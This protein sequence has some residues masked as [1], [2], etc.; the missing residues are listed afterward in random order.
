V[1]D[2]E[3]LPS[4]GSH[5]VWGPGTNLVDPQGEP[6]ED[7]YAVLRDVGYPLS[8]KTQ[9]D[10][11]G[12]FFGRTDHAHLPIR[13][14]GTWIAVRIDDVSLRGS[15]DPH[16]TG[17]PVVEFQVSAL[18]PDISIDR[19]ADELGSTEAFLLQTLVEYNVDADGDGTVD[20]ALLTLGGSGL[21]TTI[22][23]P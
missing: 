6:I 9:V 5:W 22:H 10:G 23:V 12:A 16:D 15:V 11:E 19:V 8:I 7:T 3:D 4:L 20:S 13:V 17:L 1:H 2:A 21:P 14:D 18:I